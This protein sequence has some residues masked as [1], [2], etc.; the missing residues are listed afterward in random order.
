M[1]N[2]PR[3]SMVPV[4]NRQVTL[5]S[6]PLEPLSS[7]SASRRALEGRRPGVGALAEAGRAALVP[8]FA[9]PDTLSPSGPRAA[10]N[11]TRINV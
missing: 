9:G 10:L 7:A 6:H 5:F 11:G 1:A 4:C 8:V 2:H 3:H